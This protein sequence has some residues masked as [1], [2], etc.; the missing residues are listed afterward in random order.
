[1][2]LPHGYR[3]FAHDRKRGKSQF[4]LIWHPPQA[5][6]CGAHLTAM[7]WA[8]GEV[9]GSYCKGGPAIPVRIFCG[10]PSHSPRVELTWPVAIQLRMTSPLKT[11]STSTTMA[12]YRCKKFCKRTVD[13]S[14]HRIFR[15]MHETLNIDK[16]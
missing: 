2:N 8:A 7:H 16:K 14:S 13:F 1:V 12:Q 3:P 5:S 15:R 4:C 9:H 6:C 10:H 11:V